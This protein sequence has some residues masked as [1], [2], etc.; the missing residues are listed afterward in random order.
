MVTYVK[1]RFDV[2]A[3]YLLFYGKFRLNMDTVLYFDHFVSLGPAL[4]GLNTGNSPGLVADTGLAFWFG[5]NWNALFGVKSYFFQK[6]HYMVKKSL[7]IKR[8][9][10]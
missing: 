2:T 5:K 10:T 4:I 1:S 8:R 6:R 7:P 3:R 9:S